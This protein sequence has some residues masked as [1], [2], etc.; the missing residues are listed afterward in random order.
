[1][2]GSAVRLSGTRI[3]KTTS[4]TEIAGKSASVV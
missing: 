4:Y 3:F 1:L 2:S